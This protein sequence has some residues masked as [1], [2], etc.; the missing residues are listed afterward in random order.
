MNTLYRI[1]HSLLFWVLL[2]TVGCVTTLALCAFFSIPNIVWMC[3][4]FLAALI[5]LLATFK[6]KKIKYEV[7][8]SYNWLLHILGMREWWNVIPISHNGFEPLF[9]VML[10]A[11]PLK[12]KGH[13][14]KIC[15]E[16]VGAILSA[17]EPF[18]THSL[19]IFSEPVTPSDWKAHGVHHRSIVTPDYVGIKQS[20]ILEGVETLHQ[21][22]Q[23]GK[24]VYVHCK[25]GRGRSAT[26]VICY[27]MKYSGIDNVESAIAYV[28][29]CRPQIILNPEQIA[30]IR[31]FHKNEC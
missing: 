8:L 4:S 25:A 21:W 27:L 24:R 7:T 26:L 12:N 2:A 18:E 20:Q 17:V 30:T 14:E 22:I 6:R 23:D 11:L 19:G 16:G 13:I 15:N 1:A 29:R 3:V 5:V 28:T 10:G 9:G 31:L